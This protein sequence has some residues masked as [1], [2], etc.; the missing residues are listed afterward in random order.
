MNTVEPVDASEPVQ[1]LEIP[2]ALVGAFTEHYSADSKTYFCTV[3]NKSRLGSGLFSLAL[4]RF[5]RLFPRGR[6][7]LVLV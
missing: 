3:Y 1:L 4:E 5:R 7:F 2:G 6:V